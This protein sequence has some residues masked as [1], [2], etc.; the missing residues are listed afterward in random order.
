MKKGLIIPISLALLMVPA[1]IWAQNASQFADPCLVRIYHTNFMLPQEG[2]AVV[3]GPEGLFFARTYLPGCEHS[4]DGLQVVARGSIAGTSTNNG[5]VAPVT[6]VSNAGSSIVNF[7]LGNSCLV[8]VYHTD[9]LFP[10]EGGVIIRSADQL[11]FVPTYLPECAQAATAGT[12]VKKA[13][14]TNAAV[15]QPTGTGGGQILNLALG[16]PCLVPIY[17]TNFQLP[18]EG[19]KITRIGNQQYFVRTYQSGCER[20]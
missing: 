14:D 13:G 8:P 4:A 10:P 11:Y 19:G 18:A 9:F 3:S 1:F 15:I 2:G 17:H 6:G 12:V 20:Y 5:F 16:D 7:F